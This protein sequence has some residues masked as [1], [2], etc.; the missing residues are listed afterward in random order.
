MKKDYYKILNLSEDDKKLSSD[1]LNKKIKNNFRKLAMTHHPDK[2]GDEVKFKEINEAYE[3]LSDND[4]KFKYDNNIGDNPFDGGN[5]FGGNNPF[6]G[7]NPFGG[8]FN[9][10]DLFSHFFSQQRVKKGSDLRIK[11]ILDINEIINGCSKTIKYPRNINK[12][13]N[14]LTVEDTLDINFPAGVISGMTLNMPGKGNEILDGQSGDLHV[15]IEETPYKEF[16]RVNS[17]LVYEKKLSITDFVLG[18]SFEINAPTGKINVNVL[19]GTEVGSIQTFHGKGIPMIDMNG[20][21]RGKG[22]IVIKF[23]IEIPKTLTP[24]KKAIFEQL[25]N[26]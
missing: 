15:I 1:E 10:E 25:K 21:I 14:L 17:D 19:A 16:S 3:V 8:G 18:T 24:K 11:V 7:S 22:N 13:G 26:I 23:S 2:G 5:P 4:K 9:M 12:N 20:N 6:G